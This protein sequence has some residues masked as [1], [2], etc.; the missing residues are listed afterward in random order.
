MRPKNYLTSIR[1]RKIMFTFLVDG[2]STLFIYEQGIYFLPSTELE[3]A[4]Q[5][6]IDWQV[7][8]SFEMFYLLI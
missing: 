8:S 7:G 4:Y 3:L 5:I 1:Y 2:K 6:F